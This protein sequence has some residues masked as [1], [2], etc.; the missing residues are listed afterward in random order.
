MKLAD[1]FFVF[2]DPLKL[3]IGLFI[4]HLRTSR[5][6]LRPGHL[7]FQSWAGFSRACDCSGRFGKLPTWPPSESVWS[8]QP[9][10][11]SLWGNETDSMESPA[12]PFHRDAEIRRYFSMRLNRTVI[13]FHTHTAECRWKS[14]LWKL[15]WL[16]I[17]IKIFVENWYIYIYIY[18][19]SV[20]KTNLW[21]MIFTFSNSVI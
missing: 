17:F 9:L 10:C 21:N 4:V 3:S 2:C 13:P 11:F 18:Y 12:Q 8:R 6:K 19:E 20:F 16:L 5:L 7:W 14:K 15:L 1:F